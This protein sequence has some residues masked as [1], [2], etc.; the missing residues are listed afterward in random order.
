M[1]SLPIEVWHLVAWDVVAGFQPRDAL[2][3]VE[4]YRLGQVSKVFCPLI[5]FS[6]YRIAVCAVPRWKALDFA[7]V[8]AA[9]H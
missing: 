1:G 7:D 8:V 9:Q 4:S 5:I 2:L 6:H 3:G